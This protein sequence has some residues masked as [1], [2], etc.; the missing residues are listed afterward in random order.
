[1]TM[2]TTIQ[3][4]EETLR[5]LRKLKEELHAES[6][7]AALRRVLMDYRKRSM[8][9]RGALPYAGPFVREHNDRD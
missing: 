7:D 5:E 4:A 1:M 2:A 8:R 3:V 9:I 6:Y